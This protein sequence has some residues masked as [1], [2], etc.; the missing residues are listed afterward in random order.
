MNQTNDV[1]NIFESDSDIVNK[2]E[3]LNVIFSAL[4]S[5]EQPGLNMFALPD[6]FSSETIR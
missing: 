3:V 4:S 5:V 2:T 1:C 6:T